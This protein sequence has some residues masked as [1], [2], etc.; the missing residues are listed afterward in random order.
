M[1]FGGLLVF[2]LGSALCGLAPSVALADR[3]AGDP[4][5]GRSPP[6]WPA[7][8]GLLLGASR[9]SVVPT[10]WRCGE[11]SGARV[12]TGPDRRRRTYLGRRVRLSSNVNLPLAGVA[13]LLGRVFSP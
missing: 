12:A 1:F 5:C 4:G 10:S 13:F 6:C 11:A 3:R 8:L 7:S 9:T 2:S